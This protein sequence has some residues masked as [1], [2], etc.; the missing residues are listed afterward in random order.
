MASNDD[1]MIS[2]ESRNEC[3]ADVVEARISRRRF[4]GGGLATAAIVSTGGIGALLNAV[5]VSAKPKLAGPLLGFK[6]LPVST[7]D[8]VVVPPGYTARVLIAWGDPV[9]DGP[10]FKPDA[11]NTAAEQATQWG[12]HNDGVVYFPD[13][14]FVARAARAEQRVHRR[15]AALPRRHRRTGT[16]RRPTSRINAHGV[17][18]I[19]IERQA[20]DRAAS[21]ERGRR[22]GNGDRGRLAGRAAVAYA[23][24]ITGRRRS[25]MGGPGATGDRR[26]AL[27]TSADP[28]GRR[29]SAR[30][31]T[32]RW[33]SRRGAPTSPARRTSTATSARTATQTDART[34]VRHHRRRRR[35][36]WH[37]TDQRFNVDAGT[38]RAEP[39]RLGGR[40]RSVQSAVDAGEA[41]RAR[42]PQAR[43]RMGAGGARRPR[44]RLHGRRRAVRVH[45]P[46]RLEPAVAQGDPPRHQPARRRHPLRREVPR[47]RHRRVAAA[48]ARQSGAGGLVAERHPA[49]T[50]AARPTPSAPRRWIAPSGSTRSPSR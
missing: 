5:P 29:C 44:R 43:G 41:H 16:R 22:D 50:P 4:L 13:R 14:R 11:S 20:R 31:T 23:R 27:I 18:I 35:L 21:A 34:A 36:L 24:R 40:D 42:T 45:L 1:G 47:R 33:A 3:F 39:L 48:D 6:A 26:S 8:T 32:A 37:T 9:S 2:N 12:M 46:L 38:E 49:S 28:T 17:S 25:R 7:A 19:E 30:S 15:R 10:A